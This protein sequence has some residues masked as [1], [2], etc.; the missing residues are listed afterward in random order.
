MKGLG[1]MDTNKENR[2]WQANIS[3]PDPRHLKCQMTSLNNLFFFLDKTS[4]N[5]HAFVWTNT[6]ILVKVTEMK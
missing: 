2:T 4:L 5:N 1:E 3:L 6:G